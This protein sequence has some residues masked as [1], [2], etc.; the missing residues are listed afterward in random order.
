MK[1]RI[2]RAL[3]WLTGDRRVEA[4]GEAEARSSQ[5]VQ[6][7]DVERAERDVKAKY[8][9]TPTGRHADPR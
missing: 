9:E 3:G 2:K 4:E 6:A 7:S 8:D 1:A 5:E